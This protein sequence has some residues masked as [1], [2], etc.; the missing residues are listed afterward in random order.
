KRYLLLENGSIYSGQGFG[1]LQTAKGELVF[2]TGMTGYQETITDPSY[3]G[4]IIV[5]TYPL[6]GN[7]GINRDDFESLNPAASAIVLHELA[8]HPNNWRMDRSLEQWAKEVG[9]PIISGIDTRALTKEIR[10]FG[11]MKAC[12]IDQV[13]ADS[14]KELQT[15]RFSDQ[16]VKEVASRTAYQDPSDGP[17]IAVID[18]GLK[19]SILFSLAKRHCNVIVFPADTAAEKVL[20]ANVDGVLLSNGPGNPDSA[21]YALPLIRSLQKAKPLFGIC[22]GHQLFALANGACTY[23]MKF[24]HRGFNHAVRSLVSKRLDFT[25]QNHGYAVDEKSLA[26]TDLSVTY[27]EVNDQTVEGLKSTKYPAFS[28]Q[29]HPDA[30]PGPH[31]TDYLY[32]DFIQ[33]V[34]KNKRGQ[35]AK[36]N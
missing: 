24:G 3:H 26:N 32:D 31:D 7:Y 29:F 9:L 15:S 12:L 35:N 6:I 36:K 28:V 22:L 33:L 5:F 4:Q 21:A 23:K 17:T 16:Q 8:R 18:F 2:N 25:A 14:L 11:V 30:A 20:A 27:R 1:S 34:N 10:E 19:N 13:K